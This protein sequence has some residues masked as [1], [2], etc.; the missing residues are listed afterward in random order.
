MRWVKVLCAF[1]AAFAVLVFAGF[2]RASFSLG[3]TGLVAAV[4]IMK[5]PTENQRKR[6]M[7][8]RAFTHPA[9][10]FAVVFA[11]ANDVGG[12][13]HV[14]WFLV[15]LC[16]GLA[17]WV[18]NQSDFSAESTIDT[19]TKYGCVALAAL[20]FVTGLAQYFDSA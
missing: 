5:P 12:F 19:K 2:D 6:K 16:W 20:A 18:R 7:V 1:A 8:A 3:Y 11:T 13:P 15:V 14:P 10:L 17:Y 9:V 4:G